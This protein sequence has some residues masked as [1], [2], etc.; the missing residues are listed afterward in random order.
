MFIEERRKRI[1]DIIRRDGRVQ[2]KQLAA[3]FSVTEDAIRKDLRFLDKKGL[4]HKTYGGAVL[5]AQLPEFIAYKDRGLE[6]KHPFAKAAVGLIRPGDT[7]FIESSSFTNLMFS[8]MPALKDVT[9]VTNSI[10]ALPELLTRVSLIHIGGKVHEGDEAAYGCFAMQAIEQM[11]FDKCFLRTAGISS[12]WQVTASLEE[13]LE[14]KRAVLKQ[15]DM[16]IM[17]IDQKNWNRRGRYNVC[18]LREMD[19][20]I[21][22]TE[23]PEIIR[24]LEENE[25]ERISLPR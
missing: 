4:V 3:Q 21:T 20:V 25:I 23:D 22:D 1:V 15:S 5:P 18:D 13:S 16:A 12:D 6:G 7:V 10:H 9:V 19:A 17:L 14:L 2:V 8:A 24:L 11:N